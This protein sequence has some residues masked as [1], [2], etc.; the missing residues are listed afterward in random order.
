M[1]K[2]RCKVTLN[3]RKLPQAENPCKGRNLHSKKDQEGE[4]RELRKGKGKGRVCVW[5][6]LLEMGMRGGV[7]GR[8]K[9]RRFRGERGERGR[10]RNSHL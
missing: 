10:G 2:G 6:R 7:I 9:E 5:L 3:R 1:R 4:G 8:G